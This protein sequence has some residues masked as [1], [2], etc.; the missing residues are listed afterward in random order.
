MGNYSRNPEELKSK[1]NLYWPAELTAREASL[2]IIPRLLDTQDKFISLLDISDA[3]PEAWS[4]AL[5]SS[6]D[7]T[8]NLFLKH[9]LVLADVGGEPLKRLRLELA[10]IFPESIMRYSWRG[11]LYDYKFKNIINCSRLD[12]VSLYVDGKGLVKDVPLDDKIQDVIMLILHGGAAI[13]ETIP[14]II[15]EKCIL[16]VLIGDK[17]ELERFVKQRYIWVSRITG[18]AKSNTLGQLAQDYVKE[19]LEIALPDW[20]F[21]RGGRIPGISQNDGTTDIGFDVLAKSPNEK[22]VAIEVTF[23]FTTNSVI[24]RKSGQAKARF[25]ML[26]KNGHKIAYVIDGAGNFERIAA[27]TTICS[28]SDCTVALTPGELNVLVDFLTHM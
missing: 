28:Y 18:G 21:T 1:A 13:G 11:Q 19:T 20:K 6:S 24:E 23:Q 10:T 8:P 7:M 27:L 25:D 9:L 2:S 4:D 22:Y 14:D 16:G 5:K 15:R 3:G 26:H 12:N 17:A